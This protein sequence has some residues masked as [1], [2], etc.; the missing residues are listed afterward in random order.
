M[1]SDKAQRM[2]SESTLD[3]E[4]VDLKSAADVVVAREGA[5]PC[6]VV[7][8]ARRVT[9]PG[10]PRFRGD[11]PAPRAA[12]RF[13]WGVS[14]QLWTVAPE[15][16][17]ATPPRAAAHNVFDMAS[18][19]KPVTALLVARLQRAGVLHRDEPLADLLP[20]L[21]ATS[22]ARVPLDLL[23]SHRSGLEAHREFFV[24]QARAAQPASAAVLSEAADARRTECQGPPPAEGF[25]VVYSD[26][27][28]ILAGAAIERRTGRPLDE[29][30]FEEVSRPLGLA[31][32]SIRRLEPSEP[33]LMLRVVPTEVV[34]WR[35]GLIRG[36]VHDENAWVL[37]G[38]GSAG[39]AGLF[40]DVWSLV[41]LGTAILDAWGGHKDHW[42]TQA[43]LAPLLRV[44]PGGSHRAGFDSRQSP[45]TGPAPSSGTFFGPSTFGHLG[46]TGTSIWMDPDAE[47]VGVLLTNRVHP[48]RDHD[49]IKRARPAAY[50][51]L[52]Q[53]MME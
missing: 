18:L 12:W 27:G 39:H 22:S 32:G 6:A 16:A 42:L 23:L 50:D 25:P 51:A 19:T 37:A 11:T 31:V 13:G 14:G 46:F 47:L 28:Y 41:R 24:K 52:Y 45:G 2:S 8:A 30:V 9:R 34:P 33:G 1:V 43:D 17:E 48:T 3:A 35:G 36:V 44:R 26:L 5:A 38:T 40:G 4:A 15:S 7:G 20:E 29:L 10:L 49:A 53:R 21:A